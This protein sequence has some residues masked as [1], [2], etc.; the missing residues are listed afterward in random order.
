MK[1]VFEKLKA[2][3]M[4]PCEKVDA[5]LLKCKATQGYLLSPL[6]FNNVLEAVAMKVRQEK[7]T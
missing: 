5:C 4:L 6:L 1:G 2:N 7:E 3:I